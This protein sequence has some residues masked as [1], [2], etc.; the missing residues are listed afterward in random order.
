MTA[1]SSTL[2]NRQFRWLNP[3]LSWSV[4]DQIPVSVKAFP[5]VDAS[6]ADLISGRPFAGQTLTADPFGIVDP[7]GLPGR[8]SYQWQAGGADIPG[9]TGSTYVPE[10]GDI[11]KTIRVVIS[12]TDDHGYKERLTSGATVAVGNRVREVW[13]AQMTVGTGASGQLGYGDNYTGDSLTDN[14]FTTSAGTT[15][16]ETS[17][18]KGFNSLKPASP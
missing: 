18:S 1:S 9:A 2:R 7:N 3:G 15:P 5:N 10:P 8:F 16:S 12:F 6:G 13:A 14:T 4:G 17:V 11:G